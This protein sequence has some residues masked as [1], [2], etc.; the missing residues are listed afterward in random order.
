MEISI[1]KVVMY[2]EA[3]EVSYHVY[4]SANRAKTANSVVEKLRVTLQISSGNA[5]SSLGKCEC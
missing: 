1:N 5:F 4:F 3:G 2:H